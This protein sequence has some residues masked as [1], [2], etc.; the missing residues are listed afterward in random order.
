[1]STKKKRKTR[2]KTENRFER[3]CRGVMSQ[4]IDY[5]LEKVAPE[6]LDHSIECRQAY[7]FNNDDPD[8]IREFAVFLIVQLRGFIFDSDMQSED[9]ISRRASTTEVT[10]G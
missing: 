6:M 1:M 9:G 4:A 3:E 2:K 10:R 8:V 5:F 7:V